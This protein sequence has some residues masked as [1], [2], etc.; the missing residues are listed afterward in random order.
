MRTIKEGKYVLEM[1]DLC[2]EQVTMLI[3]MG[4]CLV[5]YVSMFK[6]GRALDRA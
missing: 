4:D 3:G 6:M 1:L 5:L 2:L